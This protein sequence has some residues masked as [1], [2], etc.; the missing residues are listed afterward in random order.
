MAQAAP[1]A[2]D[3]DRSAGRDCA[4]L[5]E[6]CAGVLL[7]GADIRARQTTTAFLRALLLSLRGQAGALLSD[8]G[9]H[10]FSPS[11]N[12]LPGGG[13]GTI[14]LAPNSSLILNTRATQN[15]RFQSAST[16]QGRSFS[17]P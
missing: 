3:A 8:D 13:E 1:T 7:D 4:A 15:L 2:P 16:D 6:D 10:T 14:A 5:G 11:T 12:T 9:G 17:R